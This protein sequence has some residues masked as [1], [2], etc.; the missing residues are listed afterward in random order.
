VRSKSGS[1]LS[2]MILDKDSEASLFNFSEDSSSDSFSV[3][4]QD[5]FHYYNS[6]RKRS[7][8]GFASSGDITPELERFAKHNKT[9][10]LRFTLKKLS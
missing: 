8:S 5:P 1:Y 10:T 4:L 7:E 9:P 3:D 6:I 2:D